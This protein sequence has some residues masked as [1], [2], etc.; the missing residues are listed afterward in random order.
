MSCASQIKTMK[1]SDADISNFKTFAVYAS[2]SS[3]KADAF[4]TSSNKPVDESL[5]SLINS[6]MSEKGFSQNSSEPDLVIFLLNSNE[7]NSNNGVEDNQGDSNSGSSGF[8]TTSAL[9]AGYSRIT[10]TK[11]SNPKDVPLTNGALVVEVFNRETKELLWVGIA[12]DFKSHI[13]DQTLMSRMVN[14]VF[15]EFPN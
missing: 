5:I 1:Y 13:A 15:K 4:K 3:F 7:I 10:N 12:K 9:T 11:T 14:R 8:P 2:N 6:K